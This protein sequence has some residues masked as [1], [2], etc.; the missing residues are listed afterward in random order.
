MPA[1]DLSVNRF[2]VATGWYT[3]KN[4]LLKIAYV[5]QDYNNFPTESIFNEGNFNGIMIEAS[6][7]F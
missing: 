1:D 3:T 4:L 7:G 2:E 6:V 5:N